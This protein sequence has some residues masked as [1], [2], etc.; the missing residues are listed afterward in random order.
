MI[1]VPG[2]LDL[3]VILVGD[4]VDIFE[5]VLE[6]KP[7]YAVIF[8]AGFAEVG[9]EGAELQER[10]DELVATADTRLLG[11]NTN[12][13]AFETFPEAS[14]AGPSPSSPRAGTRAGPSS[15]PRSSASRCRTGRRRA[16]RSTSSS[17]TSRATSPTSP[18]SG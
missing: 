1:D 12:L 17:P 18:R 11:P 5:A 8:A 3:A 4:A 16:T 15:R 13:N 9:A 14:R 10:L 6:K 2:D 7:R